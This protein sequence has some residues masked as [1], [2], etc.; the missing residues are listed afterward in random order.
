[1]KS[2]YEL[3]ARINFS[4]V[5]RRQTRKLSKLILKRDTERI[6]GYERSATAL[7]SQV[8]CAARSIDVAIMNPWMRDQIL[9]KDTSSLSRF[10]NVVRIL[11]DVR[12]EADRFQF[13]DE[14]TWRTTQ[15]LGLPS[16]PLSLE[17]I[18]ES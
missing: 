12:Y 1:M 16:G 18:T 6:R 17:P 7:H 14:A 4:L 10:C 3:S 8:L 2:L 13:I 11:E 9:L 5:I 15:R